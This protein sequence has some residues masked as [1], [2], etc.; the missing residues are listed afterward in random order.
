LKQYM[1]AI[2]LLGVNASIEG[3]AAHRLERAPHSQVAPAFELVESKLHPPWLRPGIVART[4]LVQRLLAWH[5][6]PVICVV[7]PPGYG[8]TTLL[9][10]WATRKGGRVGW[11]TV[12]RRDNDPVVLLTYLAVALDRIEPIDPGVFGALAAPGASV[13][14]TVVP[15]LAAA[16]AALTQPVALVVDNV[17]LLDNPQCLDAIV[18][19][20][21]HLPT[22][23]QL[24]L[25][26]RATPQLPVALLGAPGRVVAI[27]V[28]ELK[29]DQREARALLEGAG[30]QL[31]DAEATELIWR[32]EGW[33][34]GLYLA[35]LARKEGP[36]GGPRRD[37]EAG[38]SG[39]DRFVADYLWDELLSRLPQ[40]TVSFLTRTAVLDRMCGPLCDAVLDMTG[41]AEV[42][43]SLAGSNLLLL[44]LDR[45]RQWYRYH[46]LF[47][48]LLRAELDRREPELVAQL[49][50]RA[51]RWC[52]ANGLPETAIDHGQ[53]AGDAD[54]VARLVASLARATYAGGRVNTVRRWIGWFDDQGLIDRYPQVAVQ[55]GLLHALLGH[56][57]AANRWAEAAERGAAAGTGQEPSPATAALLALLRAFLCRD[58]VER[59]RADAEAAVAGL[60][61]ASPWRAVALA[62][63]G[64][65][66]VLAGQADRADPILAHAV[67][68]ARHA[69]ALPA[70]SLALAERCILA[71]ERH[72]WLQAE[73]LTEQALGIVRAG[74]LDDYI[75]SPLVYAVAAQTALHRRDLPR[76]HQHLAGAAR[77]RPLLTYAIPWL[78]VQALLELVR[79]YLAIDDA[80]GAR[81]VLREANDILRRRP[82]LGTLPQ[83]A[84][85]LR[86]K[87]SGIRVG[88]VG[89]SSLTRA[90]LRVLPLLPTH[91]TYREI[92]ERLYLSHHTVK[93]QAMSIYHK[94]GVSSRGQAVERARRLGL[95]A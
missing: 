67:E 76:A 25:A 16:A 59:M 10:Q 14:G 35:A 21:A 93:T 88:M 5:A 19:L 50:A 54:R 15:R 31:G 45:Q 63:L 49:H 47:R 83:Q 13:A 66:N 69:G 38:F 85:Q 89:A 8:K 73:T 61:P 80:A 52:E 23:S 57:A 87:T 4:A 64:M 1:P 32:T 29:M 3:R 41:S 77:L 12:D 74:Q 70:A 55:G 37:T 91:L 9:A 46:H 7:A 42:L 78:A 36:A 51:A 90:E 28:A 26:A 60:A 48:G 71:L 92:G 56:P 44:P 72:E 18:E 81:M 22:G 39:D 86:S 82:D 24:A 6:A 11:V 27:G 79:A 30:V 17:E 58:G 68:V 33:P 2:T 94:L 40:P 75:M 95:G 20:A 84:A 53:A 62:T 65:A 43:A 34:V